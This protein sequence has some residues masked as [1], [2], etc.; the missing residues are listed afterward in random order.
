MNEEVPIKMRREARALR[1]SAMF[2]LGCLSGFGGRY[3]YEEDF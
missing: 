3:G 2:E 1:G